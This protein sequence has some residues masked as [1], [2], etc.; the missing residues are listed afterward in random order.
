PADRDILEDANDL[1][2]SPHTRERLSDGLIGQI[3]QLMR[4]RR[5]EQNVRRGRW[6][7]LFIV[8]RLLGQSSGQE[9]D[10]VERREGR[11]GAHEPH[12]RSLRNLIRANSQ[13]ERRP[14]I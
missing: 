7:R 5:V 14:E 10:S 11:A 9:A 13:K 6:S 4:S 2:A 12:A 8:L 3:A 1:Q